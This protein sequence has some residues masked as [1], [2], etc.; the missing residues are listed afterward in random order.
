M[1][2]KSQRR[3]NRLGHVSVRNALVLTQARSVLGGPPCGEKV[4]EERTDLAM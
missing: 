3:E 4:N 2:R 1:W